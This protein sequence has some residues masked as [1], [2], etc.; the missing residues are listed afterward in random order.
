MSAEASQVESPT[1]PSL[2]GF[3]RAGFDSLK[4]RKLGTAGATGPMAGSTQLPK[5]WLP[6]HD[7][8]WGMCER[9]CEPLLR[10]VAAKGQ[11]V[12]QLSAATL[13]SSVTT[14]FENQLNSLHK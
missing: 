4:A 11:L 7:C 12:V 13:I 2:P 8:L 5:D 6:L 1:S 14:L 9:F 10:W 3:G